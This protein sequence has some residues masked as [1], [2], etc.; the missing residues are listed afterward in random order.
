MMYAQTRI[1]SG[2]WD[3]QNS[4]GSPNPGK[5]WLFTRKEKKN[6]PNSGLCRPG[7]R[8]NEKSK[9]KKKKRDKYLD[10]VRKLKKVME[11]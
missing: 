10:L 3:A 1:R 11:Y 9:K 2:E 8:Q 5:K 7:Q 6:L 4:L